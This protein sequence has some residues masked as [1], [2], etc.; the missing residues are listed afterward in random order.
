MNDLVAKYPNLAQKV[1]L[2][3]PTHEKKELLYAI[4]I[5]NTQKGGQ[6]GKM[7]MLSSIH[8]REIATSEVGEF[9]L[10]SHLDKLL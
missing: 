9:L 1:D 8:S 10:S 7:L 3:F 4:V 6:K 5:T 2:G